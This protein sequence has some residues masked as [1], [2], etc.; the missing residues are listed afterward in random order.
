MNWL[1]RFIKGVANLFSKLDSKTKK[2]LPVAVRVTE[3]VKKFMVLS[4]K[5]IRLQELDRLDIFKKTS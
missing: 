5:E 1:K 4:L 3:A 2:V